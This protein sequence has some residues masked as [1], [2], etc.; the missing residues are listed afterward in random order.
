[1]IK[2]IRASSCIEKW[3]ENYPGFYSAQKTCGL[4]YL[5]NQAVSLGKQNCKH[6]NTN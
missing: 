2:K 6:S 5:Y 1:M 4:I 3:I